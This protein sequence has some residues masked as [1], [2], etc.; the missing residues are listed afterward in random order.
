MLLDDTWQCV[1]SGLPEGY[2]TYHAQVHRYAKAYALE[3]VPADQPQ[4]VRSSAL[5]VDDPVARLF[6]GQPGAK[7]ER[8]GAS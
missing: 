5:V 7:P 1:A 6:P 4:W 2:A 8:P 3:A